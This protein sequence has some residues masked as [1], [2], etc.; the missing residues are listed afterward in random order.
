MSEKP[1]HRLRKF[2]CHYA[3]MAKMFERRV[4]EVWFLERFSYCKTSFCK[5]VQSFF[6]ICYLSSYRFSLS[7]LWAERICGGQRLGKRQILLLST[8][9]ILSSTMIFFYIF[10]E[11]VSK[12]IILGFSFSI[13]SQI[14]FSLKM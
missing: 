14:V 3:S 2:P 12:F 6:R 11:N 9:H 10:R 4:V 5:S 13:L 7:D 8:P 1:L